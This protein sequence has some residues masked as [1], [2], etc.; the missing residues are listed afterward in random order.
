[1]LVRRLHEQLAGPVGLKEE[2]ASTQ[3]LHQVSREF[4][5]LQLLT[6]SSDSTKEYTLNYGI[7]CVCNVYIYIY[8]C[9]QSPPP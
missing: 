1:M 5:V 7:M 6:C 4:E 2:Q 9:I 8:I 3:Y